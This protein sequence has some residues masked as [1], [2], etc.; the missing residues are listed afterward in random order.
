MWWWHGSVGWCSRTLIR[1]AIGRMY[2]VCYLEASVE[3][4]S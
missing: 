4:A 2:E 1:N 3:G